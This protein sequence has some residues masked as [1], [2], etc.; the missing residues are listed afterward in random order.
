MV[1]RAW[2]GHKSAEGQ[3][4]GKTVG[5]PVVLLR[6]FAAQHQM[7]LATTTAIAAAK[8]GTHARIVLQSPSHAV[9]GSIRVC[10]NGPRNACCCAP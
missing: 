1:A 4:G 2:T 10:H 6:L 8:D 3:V 7:E 5:V 9:S